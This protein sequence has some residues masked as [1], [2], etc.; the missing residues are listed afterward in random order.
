[1]PW[2]TFTCE[3]NVNP[4]TSFV[5]PIRYGFIRSACRTEQPPANSL[6]DA[7]F[8]VT[9]L[10]QQKSVAPIKIDFFTRRKTFESFNSDGL[11]NEAL[12]HDFIPD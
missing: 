2:F 3:S 4:A 10:S 5:V 6:D 9:V 7:R 1:M 8:P 11:D 12:Y